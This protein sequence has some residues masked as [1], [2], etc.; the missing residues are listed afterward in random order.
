MS[1]LATHPASVFAE[2]T[3]IRDGVRTLNLD[4]EQAEA[5][6]ESV[7]QGHEVNAERAH[8][9]WFLV[10]WWHLY[11]ACL[12]D[13]YAEDPEDF[14]NQSVNVEKNLYEVVGMY[15]VSETADQQYLYRGEL[16]S[17]IKDELD[18]E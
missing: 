5:L 13:L 8:E 12:E 4:L 7:K 17:R 1:A 16:P 11:T 15:L 10:R 3:V 2:I 18:A 6:L 9:A 14:A